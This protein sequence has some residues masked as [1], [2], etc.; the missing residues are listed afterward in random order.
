MKI[1]KTHFMIAQNLN[2]T[3]NQ[4]TK[5]FLIKVQIITQMKNL[6]M[7]IKQKM[8]IKLKQK[9]TENQN[10][11]LKQKVNYQRWKEV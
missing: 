11:K 6:K 9:Q 8:I 10:Q 3:L 5:N 2:Q 4:I 1:Y 7:M